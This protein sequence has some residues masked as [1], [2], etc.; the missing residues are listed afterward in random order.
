MSFENHN[1]QG[2]RVRGGC[3]D[4]GMARSAKTLCMA[5]DH[6][7][8]ASR[9]RSTSSYSEEKGQRVMTASG[10]TLNAGAAPPMVAVLSRV[11]PNRARHLTR[12]QGFTTWVQR[13]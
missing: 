4:A 13:T 3:R 12:L 2:R 9:F 10:V 1:Y 11:T 6:H 8:P 7:P 5:N